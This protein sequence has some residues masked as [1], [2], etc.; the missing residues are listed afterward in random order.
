MRQFQNVMTFG[1][2]VGFVTLAGCTKKPTLEEAKS[3]IE[4]RLKGTPISV[5]SLT[6]TSEEEGKD[7]MGGTE[8][9]MRCASELVFTEDT[10][11]GWPLTNKYVEDP[12]T[13]MML[14]SALTIALQDGREGIERQVK[15]CKKDEK[16][17]LNINVVFQKGEKGW[18]PSRI[19]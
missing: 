8:Y 16:F 4:S 1:F 3:V 13:P 12:T 17:K 9:R 14:V 11:I 7:S 18:D 15:V 6:K 5:V 2:I 19:K 10:K